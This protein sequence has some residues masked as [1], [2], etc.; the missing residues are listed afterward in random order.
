VLGVPFQMPAAHPMRTVRALRILLGLPHSR[1]PAAIAAIYAAYWERAEDVTRD[2]VISA[3][4]RAAGVSADDIAGA[5]LYLASD[6][7]S[8]VTGSMLV[9]DGGMTAQVPEI[10]IAS[11]YRRRH[12]R[13][14]LKR[15][16]Q[17]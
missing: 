16:G 9:V 14:P 7:A 10:L 4:L 12:G 6:D 17:D 5:V 1:W 3:A 11:M 15:D 2:D 8:W 13:K